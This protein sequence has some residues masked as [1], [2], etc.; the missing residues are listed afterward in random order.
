[1]SDGG[2][3]VGD[4]G[5]LTETRWEDGTPPMHGFKL[6]TLTPLVST[7]DLGDELRV[8]R[9]GKHWYATGP[10]G[11]Y[12]RL[13]WSASNGGQVSTKTGAVITYPS[14]G[15]LVTTWLEISPG[16]EVVNVGGI[17]YPVK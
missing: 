9:R 10:S 16:G 17:V 14:I 1:M 3:K 5:P 12:G 11:D 2:K 13:K 8:E 6:G 15:K 4:Y 7:I